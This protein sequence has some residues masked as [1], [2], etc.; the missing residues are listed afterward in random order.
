MNEKEKVI[1]KD[2]LLDTIKAL[3]GENIVGFMEREEENGFIYCLPGGK[4]FLITVKN[5]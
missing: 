5:A 2:N 1:K 4:R 3:L